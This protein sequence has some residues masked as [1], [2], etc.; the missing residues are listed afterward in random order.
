MHQLNGKEINDS[1]ENMAGIANGHQN[2]EKWEGRDQCIK[3]IGKWKVKKNISKTSNLQ[4]KI[5]VFPIF[6]C[7]FHFSVYFPVTWMVLE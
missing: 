6:S 5:G 7:S 3:K 1:M 4:L 2:Y